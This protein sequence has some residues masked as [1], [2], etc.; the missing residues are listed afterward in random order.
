M[1]HER[2]R[3][4]R[5]ESLQQHAQMST[6]AGAL[7]VG[8]WPPVAGNRFGEECIG[9]IVGLISA[10]ALSVQLALHCKM[11]SGIDGVCSARQI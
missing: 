5:A 8:A 3:M 7:D 1:W 6:K 10:V 4:T 9:Q 2:F 11:T